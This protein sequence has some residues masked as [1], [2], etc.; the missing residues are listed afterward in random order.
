MSQ[1]IIKKM[2]IGD[3]GVLTGQDVRVRRNLRDMNFLFLSVLAAFTFALVLFI[4]LWSR[5]AVVNIGFEISK[6]NSTRAALI[7]QNKRLKVEFMKLK[8][9]ERIEKIASGELQLVHP[10]GE[11]IVNI[12]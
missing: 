5:L 9:P 4:F 2:G 3:A 8:S 12:R 6:A 10:T 11:Q 7:E 1:T